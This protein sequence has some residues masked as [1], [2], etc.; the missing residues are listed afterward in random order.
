MASHSTIINNFA[1][2]KINKR[3]KAIEWR[4]NNVFC[5]GRMLFSYGRHFALARYMGQDGDQ[6]HLFLRNSDTYSPTTSCHQ[7]MTASSCKGP[8]LSV[9]ALSSAGLKFDD[10][11]LSNIPFWR[12]NTDKF[13]YR[14][15]E[16][17]LFYEECNYTG[18]YQVGWLDV[19][20]TNDWTPPKIGRYI[21]YS[22]RNERFTYGR[23]EVLGGV[24]VFHDNQYFLCSTDERKNFISRLPKKPRSLDHAFEMLKPPQ[25]RK[26]ERQGVSVQRQGEWF[27]VSTEF[28]DRALSAL[29]RTNK[30]SLKKRSAP[31]PLPFVDEKSNRHDC[32]H[33]DAEGNTYAK[34]RV[35][36]RWPF[37][38]VTGQHKTLNLGDCWHLVYRAELESWS[39]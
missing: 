10:L 30:T 36:H 6:Q 3:A 31:S 20:Y 15:S 33:F 34:G 24:V 19:T 9:S 28:G 35:Y 18:D 26:A 32:R 27:F 39:N 13:I 2:R 11:E 23:W 16:T 38:K 22:G 17:G 25:V 8:S 4:G 21:G 37:G 12:N 29:L 7:G 14:D 1:Q 5:D